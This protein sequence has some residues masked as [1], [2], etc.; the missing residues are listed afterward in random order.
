MEDGQRG[1]VGSPFGLQQIEFE[2]EGDDGTEALRRQA[3]DD[4]RQG[5]ARVELVRPPVRQVH[6]EEDLHGR[7]GSPR[8]RA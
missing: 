8:A 2:L 4:G 5:M 6:G 3:V 1:A 7:A